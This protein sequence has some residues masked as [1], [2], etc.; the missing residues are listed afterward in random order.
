MDTLKAIICEKCGSSDLYEENGFFVCKY[1]GTKH[2]IAQKDRSVNKTTIDLEDDVSRLLQKCRED[3]TRA[4]KYAQLILEIDPDNKEAKYYI[5]KTVSSQQHHNSNEGC[6]VA[7]CVYG[8]Y[9]CPPVWTLRRYRDFW[10]A[11]T[12]Y[13]RLFISFYYAVSPAL[14]KQFGKKKWFIKLWKTKLDKTVRLLNE[15][16]IEDT[17]YHDR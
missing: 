4:T 12:L 7:T 16:G 5:N 17:P 3:P 8:S 9:D 11:K 6:Y 15:K 2:L 13:G 1:C 14:V 10:L